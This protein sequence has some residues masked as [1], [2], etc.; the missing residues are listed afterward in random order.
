L[1]W[2][3]VVAI[4]D[5]PSEPEGSASRVPTGSLDSVE[6]DLE[7]LLGSDR[8]HPTVVRDL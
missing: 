8:D 2:R 1:L 3:L 7:N 6:G 4:A 5:D